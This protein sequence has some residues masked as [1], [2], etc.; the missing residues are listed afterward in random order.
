LIEQFGL[1]VQ[2]E[3]GD[4]V[5]EMLEPRISLAWVHLPRGGER[6]YCRDEEGEDDVLVYLLFALLALAVLTGLVVLA[7][8]G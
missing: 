3:R 8:L 7:D 6:M 2:I 5:Q 4:V 1:F